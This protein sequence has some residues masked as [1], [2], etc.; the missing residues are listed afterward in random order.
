MTNLGEARLVRINLTDEYLR[1]IRCD[2][3]IEDY[4][5]SE[6][7]PTSPWIDTDRQGF[8]CQWDDDETLLCPHCGARIA[9]RWPD[10]YQ[11][12]HTIIATLCRSDADLRYLKMIGAL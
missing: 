3:R 8:A 4:L 12:P 2:G 6:C 9:V 5:V 7:A 1:C 11:A 10:F